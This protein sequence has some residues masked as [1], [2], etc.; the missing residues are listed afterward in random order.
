MIY[1]KN[2]K[3][4]LSYCKNFEKIINTDFMEG[5]NL[6]LQLVKIYK[7]YIFS[8]DVTSEEEV[9]NAI[10]I[11]KIMARYIDDYLFRK[12]L[13][14]ELLRIKV[15]RTCGNVIKTIVESIIEIFHKVEFE[16]TRKIYISKW[17]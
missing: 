3:V 14:Q 9:E 13:K 15:K 5:D 7:D 4:V 11:D 2:N 6:S 8:I 1:L 16:Q 12:T 17:I 10:E